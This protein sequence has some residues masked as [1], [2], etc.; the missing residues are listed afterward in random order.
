M[1]SSSDQQ[2][3][4]AL[5][6]AAARITLPPE[7][8]WVRER[9]SARGVWVI[10]TLTVAFLA[11]IAVLV[12][13]RGEPRT[14]PGSVSHTIP[15]SASRTTSASGPVAYE[16]SEDTAWAIA[17]LRTA[18]DFVVLRPSWVPRLS[19]SMSECAINLQRL[20]EDTL[21]DEYHVWYVSLGARPCSLMFGGHLDPAWVAGLTNP[22]LPTVATFAARGTVVYVRESDKNVYLQ[23]V[24]NGAFYEI[25]ANGYD[26]SDLVRALNSLE[27]MR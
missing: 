27:P 12:T 13:L 2:V 7:S 21:T 20:G 25:I 14:V 6:V 15:P 19:D 23:W 16:M 3:V 18:P 11:L 17:R 9:P 10:A 8:R 1:I 4:I 24:E 5:R 26:L 22:A